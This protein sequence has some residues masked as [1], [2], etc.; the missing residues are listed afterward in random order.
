[1]TFTDS[2]LFLVTNDQSSFLYFFSFLETLG[3]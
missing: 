2:Q 3:S 1:M